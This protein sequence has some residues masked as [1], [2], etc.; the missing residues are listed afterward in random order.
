MFFVSNF[1][2]NYF[3][4]DIPDP[5]VTVSIKTSPHGTQRTKHLDNDV[6]PVWNETFT[7]YLNPNI[8]NVLG[9]TYT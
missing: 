2:S 5:Y 3:S 4:V 1:F 7:F 9:K 6:N 8:D